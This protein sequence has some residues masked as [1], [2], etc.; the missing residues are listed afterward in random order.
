MCFAG[1]RLLRTQKMPSGEDRLAAVLK[2]THVC[3]D[4]TCSVTNRLRL[5]QQQILKPLTIMLLQ[6]YE[7]IH[8]AVQTGEC[9]FEERLLPSGEGGGWLEAGW[10]LGQRLVEGRLVGWLVGGLGRGLLEAGWRLGQFCLVPGGSSG[11]SS[12]SSSGYSSGISPGT[13]S[14]TLSGAFLPG[15]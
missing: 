5:E 10:R 14:D 4:Y 3:R 6:T 13:S 7:I 8:Y 2:K 9:F 1:I 11:S 15:E 12:G